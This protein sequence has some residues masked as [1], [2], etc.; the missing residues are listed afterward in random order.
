VSEENELLGRNRKDTSSWKSNMILKKYSSQINDLQ[1]RLEKVE[2]LL[3][4]KKSGSTNSDSDIMLN[5]IPIEQNTPNPFTG[6]TTIA[7]SIPIKY[8]S[9]HMA[10]YSSSGGLVKSIKLTSNKGT[11]AYKTWRVAYRLL[12]ILSYSGW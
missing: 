10:F 1:K 4:L 5:N 3:F 8:I 6:L 12:S 11:I 7:Y 2:Q 9:A